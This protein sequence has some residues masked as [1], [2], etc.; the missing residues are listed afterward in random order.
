MA[1]I[2]AAYDLLRATAWTRRH[3]DGDGTGPAPIRAPRT[4]RGSWLAPGDAPRAR[5]R[6]ARRARAGGGRLARHARLDLG[7]PD[8]R[9]SPPPT[10]GC[11]GCSTTRS[12][13]ASA[14]C[15]SPRSRPW[16]T[17]CAARSSASPRSAS[18]TAAAAATRSATCGRTPRRPCIAGSPRPWAERRS[19]LRQRHDRHDGEQGERRPSPTSPRRR[20]PARA[21]ARGWPRAARRRRPRR[22][23]ASSRSSRCRCRAAAG[24]RSR[25]QAPTIVAKPEPDA[26]AHRELPRQPDAEEVALRP[27][28]RRQPAPP[29]PR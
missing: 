28:L 2:N 27:D 9:S 5:P 15:A 22:A 24:A 10:A 29:R 20:R 19:A 26:D 14:P 1:Q 23:A 6:A 8:A 12:S 21:P 16:S 11:C 4:R 17:R 13:A 18:A 7:E 25:R 3:E